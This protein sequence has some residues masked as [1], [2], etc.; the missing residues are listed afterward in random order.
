MVDLEIASA[1]TFFAIVGLL[2]LRDRKNIEFNFG[3]IIKRWTRGKELID[4]FVN[5]SRK[6]LPTIGNIGIVVGLIS[7]IIMTGLLIYFDANNIPAIA[8]VL[9]SA[10]GVAVPGTVSI[11]F[12]Y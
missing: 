11:P 8:P 2:I 5:R 10:G 9:P 4:V 6:F 7:A 3:V 12:W 1:L